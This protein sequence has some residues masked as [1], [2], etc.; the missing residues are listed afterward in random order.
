MTARD[1]ALLHDDRTDQFRVSKGL[2]VKCGPLSPAAIEFAL[3]LQLD[4]QKPG[5]Q[6]V[7]PSV[8][9]LDN[10][11]VLC[12]ATMI[13]EQSHVAGDFCVVRRDGAPFAACSQVF[14]WIKA[15]GGCIPQRPGRT[16]MIQAAVSL[17]RIFQN[18][19]LISPGDL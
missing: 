1:P 6:R 9:A 10:V 7:E 2:V 13:A 17:R 18:L 12:G 14:S 16:T 15:K 5:L 3:V 8:I 4:E 11:R 19:H